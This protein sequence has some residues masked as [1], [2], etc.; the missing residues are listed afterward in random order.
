MVLP[1]A[2]DKI[3]PNPS[4]GFLQRLL[5]KQWL[6]QT[7]IA[8]SRPGALPALPEALKVKIEAHRPQA[9]AETKPTAAP[10]AET[11]PTAAP[12]AASSSDASHAP[13][14]FKGEPVTTRPSSLPKKR[15]ADGSDS[16]EAKSKKKR[17]E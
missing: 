2:G 11:K 7:S 15:D 16:A 13:G 8:A 3:K 4:V 6:H 10:V 1:G 9:K 12:A 17:N 14:V 5:S